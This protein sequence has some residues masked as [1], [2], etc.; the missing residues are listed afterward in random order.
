MS[1]IAVPDVSVGFD[2]EK[3]IAQ[4]K[5]NTGAVYSTLSTES[6]EDKLAV[7]DAMSN[8]LMLNEHYGETINLKNFV[9]Q[10]VQ[11]RDE[12]GQ[13]IDAARSILIDSE[14]QAYHTVSEGI[15]RALQEIVGVLGH[16]SEWNVPVP[17]VAEERRSR[18]GVNRYVT[19][20][21]LRNIPQQ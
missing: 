21:V 16:P 5:E 1:E 6:F 2:A 17:V 11:L 7:I 8:T 18:N 12:D 3:A 4:F 19:L 9:I 14:G 20:R 13:M 10:A 15:L